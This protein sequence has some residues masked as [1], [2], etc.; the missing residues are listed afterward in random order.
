MAS[1]E[2]S[3]GSERNDVEHGGLQHLAAG[4]ISH[5][6]ELGVGLDPAPVLGQDVADGK[7]AFL[8]AA[9]CVLE[10]ALLGANLRRLGEVRGVVGVVE[11][12]GLG[13]GVQVCLVT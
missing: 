10:S 6:V 4:L 12:E 11:G 2:E 9:L 8:D 1:G 3:F 7:G 5:R 13:H